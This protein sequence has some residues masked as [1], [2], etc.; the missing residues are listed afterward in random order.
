MTANAQLQPF[1]WNTRERIKK[2]GVIA[3]PTGGGDGIALTMPS[4]GMLTR[5]YL[6]FDGTLTF[7]SA[8]TYA[9]YGIWGLIKRVK[10][11]LNNA[12]Q[13]LV[14]VSG[15]GLYLLNATSR[16][17][18]KVD[19]TA[20]LDTNLYAAPTTTGTGRF[21]LEVPVNQSEGMNFE[22]GMINLQAPEVQ[23]TL[24]LTFTAA[25]TTDIATNI[26][27]VTGNVAVYAKFFEVPDPTRVMIPPV[28][29]HK[30]V[31][32]QQPI[33]TVG[34]IIYTI[35]RAGKM[36]KLIQIL[37]LNGAR[38]DS[39]D[40]VKLR[41]QQSDTVDD[42][43]KLLVKM[44]HRLKYGTTLPTGV[45][46]SDWSQGYAI[47]EEGDARDWFDTERVTTTEAVVTVSSGATLGSGNNTLVNIREFL[48]IPTR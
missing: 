7:S 26:T 22:A 38:S 19:D 47:C 18:N 42:R 12:A 48:Q 3:Y 14:D 41:L 34:D 6:V 40:G 44:E 31:E 39:Y 23:C 9:N 20:G 13:D 24:N 46:V 43:E 1:R 32:Q 16:K 33:S 8:G 27:A 2:I 10:L 30:I 29:L 37:N 15:F 4:I 21:V 17:V 45:I 35:P 5:L 11:Q 25:P 36:S 28:V